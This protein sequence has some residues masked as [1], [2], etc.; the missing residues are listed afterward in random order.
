MRN[1]IWGDIA[2]DRPETYTGNGVSILVT[3]RDG[4]I[5]SR[6]VILTGAPYNP[7]E[8][9]CSLEMRLRELARDITVVECGYRATVSN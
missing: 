2:I 7:S 8:L 1:W 5:V 9:E 3:D 6:K 4:K